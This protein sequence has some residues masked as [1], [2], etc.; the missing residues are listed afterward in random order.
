MS[1]TVIINGQRVQARD[2]AHARE[3]SGVKPAA[4]P[5]NGQRTNP[6]GDE[7]DGRCNRCHGTGFWG[8]REKGGA[9]FRCDGSGIAPGYKK[10]TVA[11]V[12]AAREAELG[13]SG[14]GYT[15]LV[16]PRREAKKAHKA[17]VR[18]GR[19]RA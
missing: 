10:S 1:I 17:I 11:E 14:P 19:K 15:K 13:P 5:T 18:G 4:A 2:L 3:L 8:T 6:W 9:C 12:Q 7:S 16:T